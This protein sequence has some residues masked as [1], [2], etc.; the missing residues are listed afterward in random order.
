LAR[1]EGL[2]VGQSSGMAVK[3]A[4]DWLAAHRD[5]IK[6]TDVVV[7]LLPDSGFRYLSK[8]YNDEWMRRNGF[9]ADNPALTA[10]DVITA[11]K[12]SGPVVAVAPTDTLGQAITAM[13]GH[14]ISQVPVIADGRV[15]GSLNER[16]VLDRLVAEAGAREH[17]VSDVMG[18]PLPVVPHGVH[19]DHLT[20]YLD[21]AEAVLVHADAAGGDG[22]PDG[23]PAYHIITRSDLIS[24]LAQAGRQAPTA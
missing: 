11:Q 21:A 24:A 17:A 7:V 4:L 6:P 3:G 1:D 15:V 9:L 12:R 18:P 16:L 20:A 8:T 19:L 5:E 13:M 14:G 2:F 22:A 23:A 10:A